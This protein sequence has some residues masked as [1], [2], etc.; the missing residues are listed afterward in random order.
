MR[1]SIITKNW[2]RV[3]STI[4]L[5]RFFRWSGEET[6]LIFR[7]SQGM[8]KSRTECYVIQGLWAVSG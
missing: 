3:A 1:M 8:L 5:W 4:E 7:L 2:M 6:A